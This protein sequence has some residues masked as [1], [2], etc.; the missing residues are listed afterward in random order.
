MGLVKNVNIPDNV[1]QAIISIYF[2]ENEELELEKN[3]NS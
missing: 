1:Q 2:D 3:A